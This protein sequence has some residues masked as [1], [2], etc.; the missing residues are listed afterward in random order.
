MPW[1]V[2]L[3]SQGRALQDKGALWGQPNRVRCS[4]N[5][6]PLTR[7]TAHTPLI[8]A[9]MDA[10]REHPAQLALSVAALVW[11]V[12]RSRERSK[13][14][15]AD[16]FDPSHDGTSDMGA[17]AV[18]VGAVVDAASWAATHGVVMRLPSGKGFMHAPLAMLPRKVST[19]RCPPTSRCH[20]VVR[21]PSNKARKF[22]SGQTVAQRFGGVANG[23][24]TFAS[25]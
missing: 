22:L 9:R 7:C 18:D 14:A 11:G 1:M 17:V 23:W 15:K 24:A 19:S 10:I 16:S 13:H 8:S 5:K 21:A 4:A 2:A 3:R 20:P 6:I 25:C 12:V